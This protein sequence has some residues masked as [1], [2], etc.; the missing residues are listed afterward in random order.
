MRTS[1]LLFSLGTTLLPVSYHPNATTSPNIVATP[2][3]LM[4]TPSRHLKQSEV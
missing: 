2:A 3:S 4:A 1:V